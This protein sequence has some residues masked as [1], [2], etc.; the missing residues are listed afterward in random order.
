[1]QQLLHDLVLFSVLCLIVNSNEVYRKAGSCVDHPKCSH[2]LD[3]T[4]LFISCKHPRNRN[5]CKKTCQLCTHSPTPLTTTATESPL[6]TADSV[7]TTTVFV[8]MG[9]CVD[10]PKCDEWLNPLDLYISCKNEKNQKYCKKSCQ[11]C[12]TTAPTTT[13]TD[14]DHVTTATSLTAS[15]IVGGVCSDISGRCPGWAK[16]GYCSKR[17]NY[18]RYYCRLSC[19]YCSLK[20]TAHG[21]VDLKP[22]ECPTWVNECSSNP[23]VKKYCQKTCHVCTTSYTTTATAS[24]S[25][26]TVSSKTTTLY[27]TEATSVST[28]SDISTTSTSLPTSTTL[29][30][31]NTPITTRKTSTII[32]AS[33]PKPITSAATEIPNTTTT[34]TVKQST[35][36]KSKK[37]TKIIPRPFTGKIYKSTLDNA[38]DISTTAANSIPTAGPQQAESR[39]NTT[40]VISVCVS[41]F[42]LATC[43]VFIVY[44]YRRRKNEQNGGLISSTPGNIVIMKPFNSESKSRD[45]K[46]DSGIVDCDEDIYT[47][48]TNQQPVY[49]VLEGPSNQQP[50]Y[51]VLEDN[52]TEPVYACAAPDGCPNQAFESDYDYTVPEGVVTSLVSSTLRP[53]G[54]V[55]DISVETPYYRV[56]ENPNVTQERYQELIR[57]MQNNGYQP[58]I[59]RGK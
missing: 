51:H 43:A 11:S 20:T 12:I 40:V 4:D 39:V 9:G 24:S 13:S 25:T 48:P 18:M 29:H 17:P 15:A 57:P 6:T 55:R 49:H 30:T 2:W 7:N 38:A 37:P 52:R 16:S 23:Y 22:L 34:N 31:I 41:S 46:R 42:L 21:C 50:V 1:M 5:N 44:F 53:Q 27:S 45:T 8:T 3:F 32:A 10:H 35:K 19:G 36:T 26:T 14:N 58:I 47:C 28:T 56:L 59:R 54:E 33:S